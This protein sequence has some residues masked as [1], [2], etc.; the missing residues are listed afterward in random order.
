[1]TKF[2]F[3]LIGFV[4]YLSIGFGYN[5]SASDGERMAGG[6]RKSGQGH[7]DKP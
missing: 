7:A 3:I 4:L 6:M 1:M 2:Q 5:A